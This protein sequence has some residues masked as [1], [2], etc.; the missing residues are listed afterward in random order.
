MDEPQTIT[1]D[2]LR[3]LLEAGDGATLALTG[4]RVE[5]IPGEQLTTEKSLEV[6][7]VISH[8]ELLQRLDGDR[9]EEALRR[10]AAALTTAVQSLG[11]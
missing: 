8:D 10:E 5:V 9:D 3:T 4:G 7:D 6:L 11:G 2:H 1:T